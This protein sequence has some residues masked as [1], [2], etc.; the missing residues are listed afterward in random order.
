MT[1]D[2]HIKAHKEQHRSFD[3]LLAD[4]IQHNREQRLSQLLVLDLVN[5]SYSQT[6]N[7]TLPEGESYQESEAV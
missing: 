3:L 5:W 2:E 7:P 1:R 6:I 4:F